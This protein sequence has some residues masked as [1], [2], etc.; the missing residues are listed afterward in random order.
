MGSAF[1]SGSV[2]YNNYRPLAKSWDVSHV[3]VM[4]CFFDTD[5]NSWVLSKPQWETCPQ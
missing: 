1:A 2:N 5:A 3:E 4:P